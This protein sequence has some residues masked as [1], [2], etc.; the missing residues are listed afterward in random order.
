MNRAIQD[1]ERDDKRLLATARQA[2][3]EGK[4]SEAKQTAKQIIQFRGATRRMKFMIGR[5]QQ[6]SIN[7]RLMQS[8]H[9]MQKAM[10]GVTRAMVKMNNKFSMPAMMQIMK[11]FEKET[12]KVEMSQEIMDDAMEESMSQFDDDDEENE[13]VQRVMDEIG[14]DL[15]QQMDA[16]PL[17]RHEKQR[18]DDNSDNDLLERIDNLR[19]QTTHNDN[20]TTRRRK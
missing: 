11:A 16:V 6:L 4:M 2:A 7:I 10:L 20:N 5:M 19:S 14:I 13:L 8:T 17:A 3:E 18:N 1:L 9:D 15:S 12:Y